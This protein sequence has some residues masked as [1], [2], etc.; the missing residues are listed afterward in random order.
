MHETPED[1]LVQQLL[2]CEDE[3]TREDLLA[4]VLSRLRERLKAVVRLRLD[5]RLRRRVD[6]SDVI[7]ETFVDARRRLPEFIQQRPGPLYLWLRR[8]AVQRLWDL[9]E[10][11]LQAEKRSIRKEVFLA[12]AGAPEAN[13]A[14]MVLQLEGKITNPGQAAVRSETLRRLQEGIDALPAA[15]REILALRFFE[16]LSTAEAASLLG[17]EKAATRKR[18]HRALGRLAEVLRAQGLATEVLG[19]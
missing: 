13:S 9:H 17:L 6:P 12:E 19:E 8:L 2:A 5:P 3:A 4:Q 16:G 14:A 10:H 15:D 7:Q 11:H 18:Y 1:D